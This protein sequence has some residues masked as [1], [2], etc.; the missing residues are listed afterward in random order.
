MKRQRHLYYALRM[1]KSCIELQ[2]SENGIIASDAHIL[3]SILKCGYFDVA[4]ME[5]LKSSNNVSIKSIIFIV[6]FMKLLSNLFTMQ[7]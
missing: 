5:E 6:S 7:S 1:W 4:D 2:N 3:T